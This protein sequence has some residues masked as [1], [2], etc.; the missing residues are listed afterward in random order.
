MA[1]PHKRRRPATA[2][3]IGEPSKNAVLGRDGI[4]DN[5]HLCVL[6]AGN[7]TSSFDNWLAL[8]DVAAVILKRLA[9]QMRE[10]VSP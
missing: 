7:Q 3:A 8:G 9:A 4:G 1:A 5:P 2:L 10:G 6:Q